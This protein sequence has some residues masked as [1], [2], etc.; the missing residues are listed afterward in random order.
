[1]RRKSSGF[2]LIELSIVLVIIGLIAGGILVGR[3]LIH[4]AEVYKQIK[5]MQEYQVALNTFVLKYKCMPGDCTK[6][7]TFFGATDAGGNTIFNGNGDGLIDNNTGIGF[8]LDITTR[9]SLSL[10]MRGT[11]QQLAIAKLINFV[12]VST[13]TT[14]VGKDLPAFVLNDRATF[15]IGANYNFEDLSAYGALGP[16]A[17]YLTAYEK[18]NNAFYM[19]ACDTESDSM[20]YWNDGCATFMAFDMLRMDQKLDDGKALT[21]NMLGF[22]GDTAVTTTNADCLINY[23]YKPINTTK[24]CQAVLVIN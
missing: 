14:R 5:Q 9:W 23:Q 8:D 4:T 7:T 16:P 1:M 20:G 21:G 15:F 3:D 19:I 11:F 17:D 12:P 13:L 2:T 6:A 18:G 22:G 10:E 24:E